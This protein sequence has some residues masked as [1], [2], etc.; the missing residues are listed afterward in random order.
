MNPEENRDKD[1]VA[2]AYR[3]NYDYT[4][5]AVSPLEHMLLKTPFRQPKGVSYLNPTRTEVAETK[6]INN[7]KKIAVVYYNKAFSL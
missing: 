6:E 5:A 1:C 4:D 3:V 7:C 2:F